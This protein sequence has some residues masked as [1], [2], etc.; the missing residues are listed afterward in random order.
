MH[1]TYQCCGSKY[2]EFGSDP[3]PKFWPNL[4]PDSNPGLYC[5]IN[6]EE[7]NVK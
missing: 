2:I 4:D 1:R 5:T 3:D 6:F 7:K